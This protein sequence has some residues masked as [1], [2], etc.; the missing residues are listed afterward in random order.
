MILSANRKQEALRRKEKSEAH[1]YMTVN[2][3]LDDH[4]SSHTGHDLLDPDKCQ[5]R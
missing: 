3:A 4:F 1:L 2:V 5:F